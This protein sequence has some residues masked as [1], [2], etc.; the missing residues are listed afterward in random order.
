MIVLSSSAGMKEL[1]AKNVRIKRLLSASSTSEGGTARPEEPRCAPKPYTLRIIPHPFFPN[2]VSCR[3]AVDDDAREDDDDWDDDD[4]ARDDDDE[5]DDARRTPREN[6][7]A[8]EDARDAR[9]R[10]GRERFGR[11]D[12]DDEDDDEDAIA[13]A[14]RAGE[15]RRGRGR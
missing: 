14:A 6:A 2:V 3:S 8:I 7:T 9:S 5:E 4:D 11:R 1:E 12:D 15:S 10:R 13:E